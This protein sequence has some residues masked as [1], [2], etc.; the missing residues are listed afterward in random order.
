YFDTHFEW[1]T[2]PDLKLV[3]RIAHRHGEGEVEG[4]DFDYFAPL[5]GSVAP[6]VAE[7]TDLDVHVDDKRDFSGLYGFAEWHPASTFRIDSGLRLNRTAEEREGEEGE[8]PAGGEEEGHDVEH[9]R[10]SGSLGAMWT[11][12]Q[13]ESDR[14]YLFANYRNTFKPAAIDFG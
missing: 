9:V 14:V 8:P 2:S 12:W 5:D 6:R 7:P 10:L 1:S 4:T 11:A 3:A 13:H